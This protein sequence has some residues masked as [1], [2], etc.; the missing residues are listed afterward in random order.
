MSGAWDDR[1]TGQQ[2]DGRRGSV[3]PLR[4]TAE[5]RQE[6]EALQ[7]STAGPRGLG[8]WLLWAA[9]TAYERSVLPRQVDAHGIT[10]SSGAPRYYPSSG[11]NTSPAA[12]ITPDGDRRILDLCAGSGA[13]GEPY[14]RAG[15]EVIRVTLPFGDVRSFEPPADVWGVLAA[16]PCTEFSLAKNGQPRDFAA[17]LETVCACLRIIGM[18]R[19]RWWALENPTGLLSRWLGTARDVWEPYEFGDPWTKRTA[20]WGAFAIPK[21]GPF[22]E[23]TGSAMDRPTAAA[24]AVTPPG[25][26]RA[27][28]EANP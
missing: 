19:P 2:R 16:P 9:R 27:F 10:A 8:P 6:L 7:A 12:G 17:G 22:V 4:L 20:L 15:Y 24:R 5:E 1:R 28:F 14:E 21:R 18:A 11:G 25:F 3:F 26:A 23:P 13:W